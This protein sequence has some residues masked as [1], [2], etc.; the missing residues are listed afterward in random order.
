[1]PQKTH[2]HIAQKKSSGAKNKQN[3]TKQKHKFS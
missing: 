1:M 3:K 2:S